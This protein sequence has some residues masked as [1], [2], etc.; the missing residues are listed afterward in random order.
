M[1]TI[2]LY[3]LIF[4]AALLLVD[5]FFRSIFG[6]RQKVRE[7]NQRLELLNTT[8]DQ[9]GT[10]DALLRQR[11]LGKDNVVIFSNTWL[12]TLYT[13]SGIKFVPFR[14]IIYVVVFFL[15]SLFAS[16]NFFDNVIFVVLFTLFSTCMLC[17]LA[18]LY[19]R[20]RRINKFIGQLANAIEVIIRSISAGHPVPSA[21]SLVAKEVSDPAGTEFG[22]L[23]DELTY[24]IELDDAMI[25]M[26]HRVGA[27]DLKL[28]AI[29]MNVQRGTGGNLVEIL[30]NLSKVIRERAMIKAKIKAISAEGRITAVI[31][32]FFPFGLYFL[33]S[34]MAPDY[35]DPLWE[36]GYGNIVA[37]TCGVFMILGIF[38]LY[39]L[40]KFDF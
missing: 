33:I 32:A 23:S 28:M 1:S 4:S 35:F 39:R 30:E 8:G 10:Y 18:V 25:N 7:I 6:D 3:A 5:I 21:I 40:V 37:T 31:M 17:F 15:I 34:T 29:S 22:I 24:G 36:S 13:Q 27:D 38:I 16:L 19:V 12:S 11:R 2:I 9:F 26:A 14:I 20:S